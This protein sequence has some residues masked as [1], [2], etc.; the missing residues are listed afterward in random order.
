MTVSKLFIDT[1]QLI[2]LLE[3]HSEFY[4]KVAD[5]LLHAVENNAEFETSVLTVCEFCVKPEQLGRYDLLNDF[6]S[7][8]KEL[9][10]R[11]VDVT[12]PIAKMASK[13]RAKYAF[14]KQWIPC[15]SQQR[16]KISAISF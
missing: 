13:L 15:K 8:L 2:Y 6:D 7:I 1:A 11:L 5:F 16:S 4:Q 12:L 10:I 14:L 3:N 9:D